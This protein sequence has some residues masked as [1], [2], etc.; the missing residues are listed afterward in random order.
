M[1]YEKLSKFFTKNGF[2]RLIL[3][4]FSISFDK[5]QNGHHLLKLYLSEGFTTSHHPFFACSH[6]VIILVVTGHSCFNINRCGNEIRDYIFSFKYEPIK[7]RRMPGLCSQRFGLSGARALPLAA[8]I[9]VGGHYKWHFFS[10]FLS[11]FFFRLIA[12]S[13]RRGC[14]RNSNFCMGS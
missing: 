5:F 13:P 7:V 12:N 6:I 3:F 2:D 8:G 14:R 1:G 4:C 9:N 11:L 10:F